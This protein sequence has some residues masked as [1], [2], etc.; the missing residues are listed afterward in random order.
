M[1]KNNINQ[2]VKNIG[3]TGGI[4][5]ISFTFTALL[6]ACVAALYVNLGMQIHAQIIRIGGFCS[7]LYVGNTMIDMYVKCGL[8]A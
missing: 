8:W 1:I 7:D 3:S 4:D 6:K 5:P 2:F